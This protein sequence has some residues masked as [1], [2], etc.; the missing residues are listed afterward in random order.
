LTLG[1]LSTL[2]SLGMAVGCGKSAT[3]AAAEAAGFRTVAVERG[4]LQVSVEA[5]GTLQPATQVEVGSR[6]SGQLLRVL[7]DYND[8]VKAGQLL[9]E[10]DPAPFKARQ[11]EARAS[12][13]GARAELLRSEADL[14]VKEQTVVRAR[15]LNTRQL[16]STAELQGAEGAFQIARAQI[17]VA[18]AGLERT[19]AALASASNDVEATRITSPIDGLVL[20]RAVEAGQT[21]AASLQAPRLFVIA[22]A[23]D[24]LEV[25]AKVDESD[26]AI[27]KKDAA[28]SVTVD[29]FPGK[30]FQAKVSQIRIDPLNENGV[31]TFPVVLTVDNS[32]ALLLPGMTATVTIQGPPIDDALIVPA[33]A[34][35]FVP[36]T[37]TKKATGGTVW[38]LDGGSTG[39][40]TTPTATPAPATAAT[41]TP[42]PTG[43]ARS[44]SAPASASATTVGGTPRAINVTVIAKAGTRVQVSGEGLVEGTAVIIEETGK[45]ANGRMPPRVF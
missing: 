13:A 9:A 31:V 11:N 34:L 32:E 1:A 44:G 26:L 42:A 45:K 16:N 2:G 5:T 39:P 8:V 23:L 24:A 6:V 30:T 7:A 14:A 15:E 28:G 3:D 22:K 10:I 37:S 20:A 33:A 25:V 40:A 12:V 36:S 43:R 38:V 41:A 21:V 35:R 4:R 29:A 27:V 18:Q 17:A 19:Q